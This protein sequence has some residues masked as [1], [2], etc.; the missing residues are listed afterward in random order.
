MSVGRGGY[1]NR[2]YLNTKQQTS[3]NKHLNVWG[4]V[5]GRKELR[6]YRRGYRS[7]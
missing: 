4:K 1:E 6:F 2:D 7:S 3:K 5:N